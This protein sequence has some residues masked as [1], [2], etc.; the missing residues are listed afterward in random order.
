MKKCIPQSGYNAEHFRSNQTE[1]SRFP[2]R[3]TNQKE[4]GNPRN[5]FQESDNKKNSVQNLLHG[6]FNEHRPN[7]YE[8]SN[9]ATTQVNSRKLFSH[10]LRDSDRQNNS[11]DH[12]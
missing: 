10:V 3:F 12:N 2:S 7:A 9:L 11:A 8:N 5:E 6:R 1:N 4:A